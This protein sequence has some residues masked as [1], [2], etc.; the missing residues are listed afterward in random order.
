[1]SESVISVFWRKE[2]EKLYTLY[3]DCYYH[4]QYYSDDGNCILIRSPKLLIKSDGIILSDKE[5]GRYNVEIPLL[6][7]DDEFFLHDIKEIVKIKKRVRSSDGTITYF[8]EDKYIETENT[9]KTYD[10]C[11]KKIEVWDVEAEKYDKLNIEYQEYKNKYKYEH[12]FFNKKISK[13]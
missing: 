11:M 9:K 6:E 2:I 7:V 4:R 5:I 8:V 12:R 3:I 1:M 10:E 13:D